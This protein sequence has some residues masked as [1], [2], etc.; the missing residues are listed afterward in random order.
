MLQELYGLMIAVAFV[1]IHD[2]FWAQKQQ[3]PEDYAKF[4]ASIIWQ[5]LIA[6]ICFVVCIAYPRP[7]RSIVG[8]SACGAWLLYIIANRR[9]IWPASEVKSATEKN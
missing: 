8:F 2:R 3:S 4:R 1:L 9:K 5:A 7:V 6:G